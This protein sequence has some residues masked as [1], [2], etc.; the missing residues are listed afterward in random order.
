MSMRD[1]LL[2]RAKFKEG[3]PVHYRGV[4]HVVIRRF[5]RKSTDQIMY[6]LREVVKAPALPSHALNVPQELVHKPSLQTLGINPDTGRK[7]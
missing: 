3:D 1:E 7:Y 5:Y 2:A 6:D 4:V